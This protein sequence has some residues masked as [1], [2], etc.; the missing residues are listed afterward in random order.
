MDQGRRAQARSATTRGYEVSPCPAPP[1]HHANQRHTEPSHLNDL[2]VRRPVRKAA[3]IRWLWPEFSAALAAG[4]TIAEVTQVLALDGLEIS[5]SKLRAHIARLRKSSSIQPIVNRHLVPTVPPAAVVPAGTSL[6]VPPTNSTSRAA[7]VAPYDPLANLRDRLT[8][9]P[10]FEYDDRPPGRKE[11][12]LTGG[13]S[14]CYRTE[15]SK[16][17]L[18][19]ASTSRCRARAES[20]RAP[21]CNAW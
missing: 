14:L 21:G 5:Y 11:T 7:E 17:R 9:R 20:T 19:E 18:P 2:P 1:P 12:D 16:S 15:G 8:R 13:I 4:H 6:A 3:Q 10:D